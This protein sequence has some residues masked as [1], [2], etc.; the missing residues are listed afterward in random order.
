MWKLVLNEEQRKLPKKELMCPKIEN[1]LQTTDQQFIILYG[2][3]D[4]WY[5]VRPSDVEGRDNISI[6]VNTTHPH[7]TTISNFDTIAKNEILSKV[8][9]ALDIE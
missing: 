3:S 9:A 6:Y 7:T 4:P 5:A 8:K 2:S 1:M